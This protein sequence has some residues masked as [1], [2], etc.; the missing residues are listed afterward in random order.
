MLCKFCNTE[1]A[2]S[3]FPIITFKGEPYPSK[4]CNDCRKIYWDRKNSKKPIKEKK[5]ISVPMAICPKCGKSFEVAH[6]RTSGRPFKRCPTCRKI[7]ADEQENSQ[8]NL[9]KE[10]IKDISLLSP[11]NNISKQDIIDAVANKLINSLFMNSDNSS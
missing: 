7:H 11:N 1:K 10:Q 5:T 4:R 3:E 6:A 8:R 9:Y 2:E